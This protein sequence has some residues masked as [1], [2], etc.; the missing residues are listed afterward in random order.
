MDAPAEPNGEPVMG[1]GRR[2]VCVFRSYAP[3][4][5]IAVPPGFGRSTLTDDL[6]ALLIV[7]WAEPPFG[8]PVMADGPEIVVLIAPYP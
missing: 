6:S 3:G 7:P 1:S 4:T 8:Y 5:S 2:D